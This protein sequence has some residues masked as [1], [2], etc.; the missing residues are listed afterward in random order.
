MSVKWSWRDLSPKLFDCVRGGYS[1]KILRADLAAGLTVAVVALPLAMAFAI[2]SG[3]TPD[4]G[5]FTA[6]V[7]GGIISAL[8]GSR[9]QIGGPTG[10]FVIVVVGI[11]GRYGYDGLATATLMAGA[12]LLLLGFSGLA[13][14]IRYMPYPVTLGFTSGIALIIFSTQVKDF[15]GLSMA[16]VP[17]EFV[18]RWQAY[19][20]AIGTVNY[21]A[22]ALSGAGLVVLVLLRRVMP[23]LPGALVVVA[24]SAA[25]TAGLHLPVETIGSRFGEIASTL[26]APHLPRIELSRL[27]EL[28]PDAFTIAALAAIESLLSAVV[29]DGMTG[30]QHRPSAEIVAQGLANI[31]SVFFGGIPATG[32]IARTAVNIRA[33]A[34]TPLSGIVHALA[35]MAI[36]LAAAPL[37]KLVPLASLAAVLMLVA[38]DMSEAHRFAQMFRGPRSDVL[39]LLVTFLLTVLVNLNVAIQ[40]GFMLAA[41]LF[42]KRMIEVGDVSPMVWFDHDEPGPQAL[43][44]RMALP[45]V[46]VYEIAGPFFFGVADRIKGL[47]D[48]L[49]RQPMVLVL[50]MRH[51]PAMDA[52]GLQALRV[53]HG[54]CER[55]STQLVLSG[56]R[57][58]PHRAIRGAGL[59]ELIGGQNICP[60][61]HAALQR[62]EELL[63]CREP[64]GAPA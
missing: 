28:A 35:L 48:G 8:G 41:L 31:G 22:L 17:G 23:R 16:D 40:A 14:M 46:E 50:R 54:R 43:A 57:D 12:M 47:L 34:Q 4:R 49:Q 20:G 18:P 38:W 1:A 24:L 45:E 5:L 51:V 60:D 9:Y 32:A 3:V 63:A 53:L 39:V 62:A 33:G 36:M 7:A 11:I 13:A 64:A 44:R 58:Q 6:I 42:M 52:T 55:N 30:D 37:A 25:A 2:A 56:L 21:C 27:A 15:L 10:A 29:A 19:F 61:F 26:P 59:D